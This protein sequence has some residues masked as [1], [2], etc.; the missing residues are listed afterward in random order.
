[1]MSIGTRLLM[2][3]AG[4][5]AF[6]LPNAAWADAANA[7]TIEA[8]H[9]HSAASHLTGY[10]REGVAAMGYLE[11]ANGA[12]QPTRE[13]LYFVDPKLQLDVVE[14]YDSLGNRV[15]NV[16]GT[17]QAGTEVAI[18]SDADRTSLNLRENHG[19][20]WTNYGSDRTGVIPN[21]GSVGATFPA[22]PAPQQGLLEGMKWGDVAPPASS[23]AVSPRPVQ[24]QQRRPAPVN[25]H[26]HQGQPHQAWGI[27]PQG[28]ERI[29][30]ITPDTIYGPGQTVEIDAQGRQHPIG[31]GMAP[32]RLLRNAQGYWYNERTGQPAPPPPSQMQA[33]AYQP[34][35]GQF[36]NAGYAP[37][38]A[39]LFRNGL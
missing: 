31:Q 12:R 15:H 25:P 7:V 5:T 19:D 20:T 21:S 17:G 33:P 35:P 9:Q 34:Q 8:A 6:G 36:G 29:V 28:Q 26:A 39:E 4:F 1:M 32:D 2:V 30:Q 10:D 18:A 22:P 3:G 24:G 27:P 16:F 14:S 38:Q 23:T 11:S 37:P 13:S